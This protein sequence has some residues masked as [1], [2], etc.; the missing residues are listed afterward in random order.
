MAFGANIS[1]HIAWQ[2]VPSGTKSLAVVCHDP[3]A[4]SSADDVNREDREVP[5][6]LPRVDFYHWLLVDIDPQLAELAEGLFADGVV[7]GGKRSEQGAHGTRQGV[8]DYTDFLAGSEELRGI[9]YG[10]DGP[11]PPWNDAI[12]HRYV[13]TL[14]ALDVEQAPVASGF[15]GGDLLEALRG[16]ILAQDAITTTYSLN[17]RVPG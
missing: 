16:H 5:A 13:F 10:Y 3:D 6:D 17:P 4:P 2:E 9:Y 8:N 12:A 7:P 14:Y 11:C 1:P 15:R